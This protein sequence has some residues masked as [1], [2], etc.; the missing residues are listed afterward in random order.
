MEDQKFSGKDYFIMVDEAK[1]ACGRKV[2]GALIGTFDD[3][4]KPPA[5]SELAELKET[6]NETISQIVI[7]VNSKIIGPGEFGNFKLLITDGAAYMIKVGKY[8]EENFEDMLHI[9]CV[10]HLLH[11]L[12]EFVRSENFVTDDFRKLLFIRTSK[13]EIFCF[14]K[15]RIFKY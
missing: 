10:A 13:N 14:R 6:N 9:T 1:D 2:C 7:S 5:L 11:R 4:E 12:A 3:V 8:L 15:T